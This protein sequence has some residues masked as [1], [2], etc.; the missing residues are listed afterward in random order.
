MVLRERLDGRQ[1]A[2]QSGLVPSG[3]VGVEH[4]LG[5]VHVGLR[6]GP[7]VAVFD[8]GL[9][10]V[11]ILVGVFMLVIAERVMLVIAERVVLV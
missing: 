6:A 9:A 8:G 11:L 10:V 1:L 7:G 2:L 3:A 4:G 5:I